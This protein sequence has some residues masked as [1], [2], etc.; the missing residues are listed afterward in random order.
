MKHFS[1]YSGAAFATPDSAVGA[2]GWKESVWGASCT[3]GLN[4]PRRQACTARATPTEHRQTA[5]KEGIEADRE[6]SAPPTAALHSAPRQA[7]PQS[8][9]ASR[10]AQAAGLSRAVRAAPR[11]QP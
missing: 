4:T 6:P 9:P 10:A 7:L 1:K 5:I 3:P 11:T 8:L 2:Q